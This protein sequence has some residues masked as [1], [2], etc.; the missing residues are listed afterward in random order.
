MPKRI[1][2]CAPSCGFNTCEP[3][4]KADWAVIWSGGE[5]FS[6]SLCGNGMGKRSEGDCS[7]EVR[8]TWD[9]DGAIGV[10]HHNQG[11]TNTPECSCCEDGDECDPCGSCKCR[12]W[13]GYAGYF[14]WEDDGGGGGGGGG[15]GNYD[16]Q[17]ENCENLYPACTADC[18]DNGEMGV[19]FGYPCAGEGCDSPTGG[20]YEGCTYPDCDPDEVG[21]HAGCSVFTSYIPLTCTNVVDAT[22]YASGCY[23]HGNIDT[24]NPSGGDGT[25]LFST[26]IRRITIDRNGRVSWYF[27]GNPYTGAPEPACYYHD[28]GVFGGG[29]NSFRDVE[30]YWD[31]Q[32]PWGLYGSGGSTTLTDGTRIEDGS[33]TVYDITHGSVQLYY[34]KPRKYRTGTQFNWDNQCFCDEGYPDCLSTSS[35]CDGGISCAG[36]EICNPIFYVAGGYSQITSST[37]SN[38]SYD[39]CFNGANLGGTWTVEFAHP[40]HAVDF[41]LGSFLIT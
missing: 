11:C 24:F 25:D 18:M 5:V 2:C 32:S 38:E 41:E 4:E 13:N 12:S 30:K 1:K 34:K 26:M 3:V 37:Q 15:L 8:L 16:P 9:F 27:S 40:S 10:C 22:W 20:G 19:C 39:N 28:Y 23:I 33:D 21:H 14:V 35:C 7:D 17:W 29:G 36:D 6:T 31:F